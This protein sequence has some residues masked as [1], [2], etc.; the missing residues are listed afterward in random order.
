MCGSLCDHVLER[1]DSALELERLE[2]SNL[3]VVPLDHERRWYRFHHLFRD[4]LED[5]LERREPGLGR[6]R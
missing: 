6:A 5:E 2:R 3:F 1:S 4:M